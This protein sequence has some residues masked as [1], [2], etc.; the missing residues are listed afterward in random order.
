MHFSSTKSTH[1]S[2]FI[3]GSAF[4]FHRFWTAA[5]SGSGVC[6]A[7]R[8]PETVN[9]NF[10]PLDLLPITGQSGVEEL[11]HGQ[12]VVLIFPRC[13]GGVPW[14]AIPRAHCGVFVRCNLYANAP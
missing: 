5:A 11:A 7:N 4:S 13:A 9:S 2:H 3:S 10:T 14:V 6:D 8:T 1:P 12:S